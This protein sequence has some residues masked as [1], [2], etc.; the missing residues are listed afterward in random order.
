MSAYEDFE[1]HVAEINDILCAV[2]LL[3][4]DARTQMPPGGVETR[5]RQMATLTRLAQERFTSDEMARLLDA[6]ERETRDEDEDSYRVRAL[7]QTREQYGIARRL[8]AGL[9]SDMAELR[10]VAQ[11]VW[12]E[13]RA[14]AD[15]VRF[16]PY[17]ERTLALSRR[18]ADA[19]GYADHPYDALLLKYEPGM[20]ENRLHALFAELKAGVQPL[21]RAIMDRGDTIRSDFLAREYDEQKQKA[22]ALEIAQAFGYDLQ[23]G[24]LDPTTH[25]F[26]ISF[27]RNDVRITTRYNRRYLPAALF[28]TLHETGHGL[29]EQGVA[30]ALTRTALATDFLGLYAVGGTSFG[31]HESQSRLWENM[32]GRSRVFWQRHFDRLRGVFPESLG[33]VGT[34]DFYRAVNRVRPSLI[35]VEADEVTY[36]F[37]I[38]LRVEIETGLLEGSIQVHDL[39][40]IWHAKVEEYLGVTPPDDAQGVLQD[41]HWSNGYFASFPTYTIGNVMA[42]QFFAA[43]RRDVAG[44][45]DALARGDYAPLRTWLTEH[46]YR[47][48]RA[49]SADE[50]LLRSTG[51]GLAAQPYLDYLKGKYGEL[52]SLQ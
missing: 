43:A 2:S 1:Q 46:V 11:Q 49:F 24:R 20:T 44:F 4:W 34:E 23:R 8:P 39:P 30:P 7:R 48:G 9:L 14:R 10:P 28:G 17:L 37:H 27:T 42:A 47:H 21:L 35:R 13:A 31:A 40:E 18:L 15:F 19:I 25:P 3:T 36:N 16:A 12:A 29:Y 22:F 52:Y 32:V 6:A 45:D 26:E 50:L 41:I 33:D 5:G 51:H 38:M